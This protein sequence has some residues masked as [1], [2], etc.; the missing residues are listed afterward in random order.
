M[1]KQ[2]FMYPYN[3]LILVVGVVLLTVAIFYLIRFSGRQGG[4]RPERS[5]LD[6]VKERYARG[7]IG[8]EEF[9]RIKKDL[10]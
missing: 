9:E 5:P 2:F 10:E 8:R 3:W 1:M 4:D 6:I 7:E